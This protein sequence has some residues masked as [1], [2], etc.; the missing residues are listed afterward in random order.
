M[1]VKQPVDS[2]RERQ[3]ILNDIGPSSAHRPNMG[4]LHLRLA[5]AVHDLKARHRAPILICLAYLASKACVAYLP[6][7]EDLLDPTGLLL[8]GGANQVQ[9]LVIDMGGIELK[10]NRILWRQGLAEACAS[11]GGEIYLRHRP[12]RLSLQV[13][14]DAARI[15]YLPQGRLRVGS[16]A[17][18]RHW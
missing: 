13:G 4:G 16:V 15:T 9:C 18:K 8:D 17:D 5:A 10:P 2:S 7:D 11:D 12:D 6:I 3:A 14:A 1:P